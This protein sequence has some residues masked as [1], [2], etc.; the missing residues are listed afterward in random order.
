MSV[1]FLLLMLG[2]VMHWSSTAQ[3]HDIY[4]HLTDNLGRS[5]CHN[6]DC[7]PAHYRITPFGVEM[8]IGEKWI[9]I[10]RGKLQYRILEG[11]LGE[12]GGGHWCGAPDEG[13][14]FFTYCAIVP[15]SLAVADSFVRPSMP[16]R[17]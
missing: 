9:A 13:V 17:K 16:H 8:W 4:A 2:T 11:D 6:S 15:P 7:R 14:S 5:C 10:P 1:R 12:T 3:G